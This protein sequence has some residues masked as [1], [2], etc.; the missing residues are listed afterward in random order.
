MGQIRLG[1]F[2]VICVLQLILQWIDLP[3]G[4]WRRGFS[5][6]SLVSSSITYWCVILCLHYSSLLLLLLV[7]YCELMNMTQS[8]YIVCSLAFTL[9]RTLLSQSKINRVI[10]I[11]WGFKQLLYFHTNSSFQKKKKKRKKKKKP[12]LETQCEKERKEEKRRRRRRRRRE[13][14]RN[15]AQTKRD[16]KKKKRKKRNQTQKPNVKRKEK[17]GKKKKKKKKTRSDLTTL[18]SRSLECVYLPKCII[19]LFS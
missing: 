8:S 12:N 4:G 16:R 11:I 19:T 5:P 3:L 6:S 14:Q 10:I 13:E 2:F 17:R 7:Y 18:D 1:G 9:F 15:Q